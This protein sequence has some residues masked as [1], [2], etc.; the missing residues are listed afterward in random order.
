MGKQPGNHVI[1]HHRAANMVPLCE[2]SAYLLQQRGALSVVDVAHDQAVVK[3][4]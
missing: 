1:L 3:R 4:P 2:R